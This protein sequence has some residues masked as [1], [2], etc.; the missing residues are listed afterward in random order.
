MAC[1]WSS[2]EIIKRQLDRANRRFWAKLTT[3]ED[4]FDST[5]AGF[6]YDICLFSFQDKLRVEI[7][8][9]I[10]VKDVFQMPSIDFSTLSLKISYGHVE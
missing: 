9:E 10:K 2:V 3:L 6:V 8:F 5:M 1:Y 7:S 4:P